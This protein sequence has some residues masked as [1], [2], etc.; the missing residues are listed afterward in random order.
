MA[1]AI[2]IQNLT[3]LYG[4]RLGIEGLNLRVES[5]SVF[6]FLGPNGSGKTTTIRILLGLLRPTSGQATVQGL[7]CWANSHLVKRDVGYMPGDFR[8]YPWMT[9]RLAL[10]IFGRVRQKDIRNSGTELAEEFGLESNL[11]ADKMSRGTRQKLGLVLAL[12]HKPRVLILDEPSSG[13]DPLVQERLYKRLR[14]FAAEGSTVFLSSHNL[15]EVERLCDRVAV[16][17][18]G[19]LAAEES[20]SEMRRHA[21]RRVLISWPAEAAVHRIEVPPFLADCQRTNTSWEA[22]LHGSATELVQ[23]AANQPIED[24]CVGQ[25]DLDD[26]FQSYY[27]SPR[28]QG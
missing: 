4:D 27:D 17:R 7:D 15:S 24:I 28:N 12:A 6:G 26:L 19:T 22:R 9:C 25:P 16:L 20:L 1:A 3:K 23:W 2:A 5:G 21:S 8:V 13:L 14:R 11:R 18:E 10:E